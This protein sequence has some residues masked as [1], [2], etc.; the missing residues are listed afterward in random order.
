LGGI[1]VDASVTMAVA[2]RGA[3][4]PVVVGDAHWLP[5]RSRSVEAA[6]ADRVISHLRRPDAALIE[7]VR[8]VQLGGRTV[9]ADADQQSLVIRVPGVPDPTVER[10]RR[11]RRDVGYRHGCLVT[12]L[13]AM[14][15]RLGLTEITI[16]AFPLVLRDPD[17]AFGIATW[18]DQWRT[19][20]GFDAEDDRRWRGAIAGARDA[21]F[22]YAVTYFVV[23]GVNAR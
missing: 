4:V 15:E 17:D 13:P 6:F 5:V 19:N 18:V 3:G 1:A 20:G 14:F 16:D 12:A 21:G 9:V 11:L 7:M 22:V 2:A 23:S 8:T 10:V